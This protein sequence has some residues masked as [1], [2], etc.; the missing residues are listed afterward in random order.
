L[1]GWKAERKPNQR[2][3][4]E[5]ER[6]LDRL[7][8]HLGHSDV[9]RVT[10]DD[11]IAWKDALVASGKNPKTVNNHLAVV[12]ALFNWAV[13]NG[14]MNAN[15]AA[16]VRVAVK[17]KPGERMLSFSDDDARLIL[18]A[19]RSLKGAR[20]WVPWLLAFTGARLEEI[21]QALVSDIRWDGSNWYLDVNED[22]P[23]KSLKNAGP[24]RKVPLHPA[25]VEEGFLDYLRGLPKKGPLFADF[26]PDRF[27]KRGGTGGRVIGRWVR[28][29]LGIKDPHKDPNCAWRHRFKDQCRAAGVAKDLRDAIM[30][31]ASGD[32]AD[33]HGSEGFPLRVLAEAV[34]KVPSPL[35]SG[36]PK[37]S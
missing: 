20:R 32:M 28:K 33:T 6:V 25:L 8:H 3:E 18:S 10:R 24:V 15:P 30:G 2:T 37:A 34:A 27:G 17:R 16:R 9:S 5:W 21:C 29:T 36:E 1:K 31:H 12:H 23:G 35:S 22:D 19:A 11:I 13:A 4:Y 7:S 26:Q 14:R